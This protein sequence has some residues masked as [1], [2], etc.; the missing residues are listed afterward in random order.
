MNLDEKNEIQRKKE[1]YEF[2]KVLI[3]GGLLGTITGLGILS[4]AH[5]TTIGKFKPF[6][7]KDDKIKKYKVTTLIESNDKDKIINEYLDGIDC[8]KI[9]AFKYYD[10]RLNTNGYDL[11]DISSLTEEQINYIYS[12][13]DKLD[14][15]DLDAI[16]GYIS[17]KGY[18][19]SNSE[20]NYTYAKHKKYF[21]SS[22]Q[23]EMKIITKSIDT[24]DIKEFER[25]DLGFTYFLDG[26][27]IVGSMCTVDLLA[28]SGYALIKINKDRKEK[29]KV[30][31]K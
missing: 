7:S 14:K 5:Y 1:K 2:I 12:Y 15:N 6:L 25:E 24:N 21:S 29:R 18:Y 9:A 31:S 4:F 28:L 19:I 30:K 11:Y 27:I 17:Q 20:Y 13:L 8:S 10:E 26:N 23:Y 22:D 3:A 16:R